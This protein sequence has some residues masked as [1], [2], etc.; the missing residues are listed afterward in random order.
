MEKKEMQAALAG[1]EFFQGLQA[2][3][4][5]KLLPLCHAKRYQSG[6]VVFTQGT[7]GEYLYVIVSGQVVL[8]R[9]IDLGVRKGTVTIE[10]LEKGRVLGC[11]ST[12]LGE[13]HVLMS[14]AVCQK[15]TRLLTLRGADLRNLM[16]SNKDLG[17]N[18]ME[19]FCFLLRDRVQAAYGAL[20]KI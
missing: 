12:L 19:K 20:E 9:A 15:P 1:C 11:W 3:D 5:D 4:L 6:E 2:A 17:F 14:S 10:A 8:E 18:V 7:D 16:H 13:Q